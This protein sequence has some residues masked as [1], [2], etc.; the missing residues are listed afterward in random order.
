ME[1]PLPLVIPPRVRR[2][3]RRGGAAACL[4]LLAGTATALADC[5][6]QP[7]TTPVAQ[8]GDAASHLSSPGG[9]SVDTA[10]HVGSRVDGDPYRSG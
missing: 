8:W 5:P 4:A 6:A 10:D 2:A 7:A 1:V 9:P 3:V